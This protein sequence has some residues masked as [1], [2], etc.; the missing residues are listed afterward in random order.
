M[1]VRI[2][3]IEDIPQIVSLGKQLLD[4]HAEF[5]SNYYQMEDS[6]HETFSR[7]VQDQIGQ[8]SKLLLIAEKETQQKEKLI[9]GFIS[10]FL[11][12]LYPWFKVKMVGHIA[13]M[14]VDPHHRKVGIGKLLENEAVI[15]FR[16]KKVSYIELYVE[17]Q[18]TIGVKA[19]DSYGFLPFKKF[20]RKLI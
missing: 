13:Y 17:E 5:D 10:G 20:L 12:S 19:W 1:H 2:A 18:N 15:W 16:S 4:L 8:P 9:V 14:A 6:F 7:W 3:R 11:K